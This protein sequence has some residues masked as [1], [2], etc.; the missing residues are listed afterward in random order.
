MIHNLSV[1]D[2]WIEE[3]APIAGGHGYGNAM[4][5][6]YWPHGIFVDDGQTMVIAD[7]Y[8]NRVI[9]WKIGY[10]NGRVVAGGRGEGNRLDQLNRPTD[11][12]IDKETDSLIIC[13]WGNRRVVRWSLHSGAT[14]GEILLDNI[15]C[16][17][18]TMDRQRHLYVSD[19]D[20]HEIRRYQ[21]G[22]RNG[23]V[24]AGGY[25]R[26]RGLN[27]LNFPTFL[28]VDH[29]QAVYVSDCK[30]HRVMKWNQTAAE[31]IIVAGGQG[32]GWT[33]TQLSGPEGLVVDMSGTVYVADR[34]NHRVM[35]WPK[36]AKYGL[37][38]RLEG[39][40]VYYPMGLSFDQYHNLYA[41]NYGDHCIER[42]RFKSI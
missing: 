33:L 3:K 6:F 7:W 37:I 5:Q 24:V 36:G 27:Q 14:Q 16:Y 41:V 19:T 34:N 12:L 20:K 4:N 13:D 25:G 32:E 9:E 38:I 42:F 40:H 39:R 15:K 31:G 26:G 10:R 17:G 21:M 8:N 1:D 28:F 29:E 30:N 11:V 2:R 22:D 23:T 18:L 35:A